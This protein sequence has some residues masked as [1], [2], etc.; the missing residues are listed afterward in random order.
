MGSKRKY[1]TSPSKAVTKNPISFEMIEEKLKDIRPGRKITVWVP[2]NKTQDDMNPYRV[3]QG[4][5]IRIYDK[6]IH[7]RG[8]YYNECFLKADLYKCRYQVR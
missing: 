1:A 6:H 8:K 7:I 5:V 4:K 3:V 2:R